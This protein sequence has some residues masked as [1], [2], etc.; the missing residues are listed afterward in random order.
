MV[1]V[2]SGFMQGGAA[3]ET[4]PEVEI[5]VPQVQEFEG[6]QKLLMMVKV[7]PLFKLYRGC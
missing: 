7:E 4:A 1:N 6:V 5:E 3:E 2:D